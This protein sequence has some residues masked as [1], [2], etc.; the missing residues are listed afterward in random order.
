MLIRT[1]LTSALMALSLT[2]LVFADVAELARDTTTP[3]AI[4]VKISSGC[5]SGVVYDDG[6]YEN[7]YG[8]TSTFGFSYLG[9]RTSAPF[10]NA[11][12]EK[13][14]VCLQRLSGAA[15]GNVD[16]LIHSS[17]PV[18]GAPQ[19]LTQFIQDIPVS[20][21]PSNGLTGQFYTFDLSSLNITTTAPI[22]VGIRWDEATNPG[23]FV[24]A[25]ESTATSKQ[26]GFFDT[27]LLAGGFPPFPELG[28]N[29][30]L[31][32]RALGIRAIFSEIVPPADPDP[33]A[34]PPLTSSEY[35][36]FRFWVRISDSRIGTTVAGCLPETVCVAGAIPTRAEVFVRIV[37]PKPNG[38]LWPNLVKF[39]TTKTEVWI[40]QISTGVVKYYLLPTLPTDSDTLPGV[41]DKT[42]FLP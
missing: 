3:K 6:I 21:V 12:L 15:S 22:Y 9:Q 4:G 5:D 26:R 13:V 24:C 25:D 10:S 30:A 19:D 16:I 29:T 8:S 14:C 41:V 34:V 18:S 35:P 32:Y 17:N 20:N 40:Q 33:P 31:D 2:R 38:Y 7:G 23:F 42:G 28:V 1:V 11:K 36:D 37:G 39:N 27:G